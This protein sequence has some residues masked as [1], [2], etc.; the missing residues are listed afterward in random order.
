MAQKSVAIIGYGAL[1]KILASALRQTLSEDYRISGIWTHHIERDAEKI[2]QDGFYAYG[3]F[4]ELLADGPD[5]AVEIASVEAVRCYGE[6]L[7]RADISLIVTSVGALAEEQLRENMIRAARDH[8]Q[9]IHV[10][11]GAVGGFDVL[12]TVALMGGASG[13]IEN[14]K[15]PEGLRG[16][17]YLDGKSLSASRLETVFRG[18]ARE[19]ISGFPR[20]V[21]V[22]VASALAS[23]GVDEMQVKIDSCPGRQDNMHRIKVE[24]DSVR[25]TVEV[26]S[27]PDPENPR[28]SV[29]T[30][31]S[32]VALLRSLESPIQYF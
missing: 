31:W 17:P 26:A 20:N 27:S 3:S 7:L 9:K 10:T 1:G 13:C 32:V 18:T 4:E 24:N 22:A 21:N 23:V 8:G 11:S 2:R 16:A 19:A 15:A 25:V 30:A 28:S 29:M 5:Y 6:A 12:Q 14:Y